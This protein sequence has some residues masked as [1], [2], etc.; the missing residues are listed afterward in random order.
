MNN[1][2]IKSSARII[3]SVSLGNDVYLAQETILRSLDNSIK[4]ENSS[5]VLENS[6]IIGSKKFPVSVGQKTVFGHKCTVLGST[7]GNLCEIGNSTIFLPGSKIG[8]FCIFGEGTIIP[9]NKIIPDNSVVV[10]RPGRIIRT[11]TKDDKAMINRMRK[12]NISLTEYTENLIDNNKESSNMNN[13]YKFKDKY[14]NISNTAYIFETAEITGDVTIGNNSIIGAGVKIIGDSHGPIKIGNNVE[15]LENSVLHLLPNNELII[16]DNTTIGPNS[17]I[18]GTT[19]GENS[20]IE[21]GAILCDN[22]IIGK[23]SLVKSGTLI[24]QRDNFKDNSIIEGFPGK[25]IGENKELQEKPIWAFRNL[26]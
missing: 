23:N 22:S 8:N 15:I 18:H 4:I 21:S 11:L 5:W 9:E 1:L 13:L 7:I 25:I 16:K 17:M 20:I 12:N 19:I 6:V 26:K 3:G 2:N 10:G 14:P 24:K